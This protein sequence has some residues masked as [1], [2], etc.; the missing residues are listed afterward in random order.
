[1]LHQNRFEGGMRSKNPDQFRA[2]IAAETHYAD[3]MH[4]YLFSPMNKYTRSGYF[5]SS[6]ERSAISPITG[7]LTILPLAVWTSI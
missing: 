5:C 6:T 3:T 2:T 4:D 1:M 7:S